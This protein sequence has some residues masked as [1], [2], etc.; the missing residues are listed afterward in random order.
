MGCER[1][2]TCQGAKS[3][4]QLTV[5]FSSVLATAKVA[6]YL[7]WGV[8]RPMLEKGEGGWC[9]WSCFGLRCFG[10]E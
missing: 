10:G 6:D 7:Q 5:S 1:V 9:E 8:A 4:I 2:S 3:V